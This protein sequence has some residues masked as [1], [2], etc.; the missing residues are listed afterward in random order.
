MGD[1]YWI[2][3]FAGLGVA[4]GIARRG[5]FG[6]SSL[7]AAA[8]LLAAAVG[9]ALGSR[10]R[11]CGRRPAAAGV[12]GVLG[13]ALGRARSSSP[14]PSAG[15]GRGAGRR[16][17]C[18]PRSCSPRSRSFPSSAT[19]RRSCCPRSR[20]ACAAARRRALRGAAH[21]RARLGR[22][23]PQKLILVVIDGLTPAVFEDAVET[24][25]RPGALVPGRNGSYRR[26]GLDVPLADAGLP[27]LDRDRRAPRRAPASRTSSGTTAEERRLVEY[28]SSFAAVRA[29]GTTR[30]LLDAIFNMNERA[31]RAG[32][33]DGLRGARGRGPDR[34]RGQHHL[35]PRAAR[36]TCRS[37][38]GSSAPAYGPKR[39]FFY[40]LFESDVTGAPLAV[41]SRC[42]PARS[43][44]TRRSVGRWLVTR[45]GFDFLVYYLPDYDFASHALG[46]EATQEALAPQR[47]GDRR[48]DRG[49]GRAG[50]VPGALRGARSAPTT[51]RRAVERA[52]RLEDAS[53]ACA[54]PPGDGRTASCRDGVEPGRDGLPA[55]AA[56][57]RP[58]RAGASG[59]T[60]RRP[61]R[62]C[63]SAK[64]ARR[65]RGGTAR[66]FAS[67]RPA[68]GWRTSGDRRAARPAGRARAR[69]GGAREPE[70]RRAARLRRARGRVRRPRRAPPRRRRQPR[71]AR[72][73]R[74]R[75]ADAHRRAGPPPR[76]IVDV[77]PLVLDALRRRAAGVRAPAE[78]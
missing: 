78:R 31:P 74:L 44:P 18:S 30:S 52:V 25:E 22:G 13:G 63:S 73:G 72:A 71:L 1:W 76:R 62:S 33:R 10:A 29:A 60:A 77:A 61:T 70:R 45:D 6:R 8:P 2:G 38:P 20:R 7:R 3:V 12:G 68:D 40:N 48:A 35:L 65:W 28:G 27:L 19:S 16:L 15:A 56:A 36:A 47:R 51:G 34:G 21:P 32:R 42:A 23:R 67:P 4:L 55:A 26:G 54:L 39:F 9:I 69:L 57:A 37:F 59:S 14:A 41:F 64:A 5:P 49:G 43:T 50:R 75:G 11:L 53:R 58:R 66:S 17:S 46:P 24:G